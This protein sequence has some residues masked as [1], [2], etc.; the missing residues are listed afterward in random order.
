MYIYMYIY[1]IYIVAIQ[2]TRVISQLIIYNLLLFVSIF[3]FIIII[4]VQLENGA[5]T[6]VIQVSRYFNT[7]V[8]FS[9]TYW[10]NTSDY[11]MLYLPTT[12]AVFAYN[13]FA[14]TTAA[15]TTSICIVLHAYIVI[16]CSLYVH[17]YT[18]AR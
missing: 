12:A 18:L 14:Q 2:V 3:F 16:L 8:V 5:T 11:I 7:I 4:I 15:V 13:Y 6:R 9:C 17:L 10:Y 1:N